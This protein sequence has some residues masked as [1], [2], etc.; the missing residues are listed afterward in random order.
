MT[1]RAGQVSCV[2]MHGRHVASGARDKVVH[3]WDAVTEALVDAYETD[4]A[5]T[6][7]ALTD[8]RLYAGQRNGGVFRLLLS[9][10][11]S[12]I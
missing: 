8:R 10:T 7:V 4:D 9:T 11:H 6:A 5:V 2:A 1:L 12:C 3:V